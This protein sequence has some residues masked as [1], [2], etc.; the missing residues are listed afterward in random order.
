MF[1]EK[2]HIMSTDSNS[3]T[4][5]TILGP[6]QGSSHPQFKGVAA[7]AGVAWQQTAAASMDGGPLVLKFPPQGSIEDAAAMSPDYLQELFHQYQEVDLDYLGSGLNFTGMNN[8]TGNSTDIPE[9]LSQINMTN[10]IAYSLLLPFAAVGNL[11]VFVALFRNR[12]RKSRVNM[13]IMHLSLADMIVTFV[14][15][16]TEITW[17]ITIQWVFGNF[18]CKVYKFFSAFGFYMSSMVLVCIS[19]DRYFAV[20]HP[21]KVNDAQRRGKIMLF[22]AW[23][24]SAVISLPQ[25]SAFACSQKLRLAQQN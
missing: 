9:G 7:T 16:P 17:H 19:L 6:S 12:H 18:G 1:L 15:L 25:V 8:H 10:L 23:L 20:L 2:R 14:F 21:L 24:I 5:E 22:F 3:T 11:M 4:L 13:M